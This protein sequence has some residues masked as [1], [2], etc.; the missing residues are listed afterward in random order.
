[1]LENEIVSV[2][3]VAKAMG[4]DPLW[5]RRNWR[6][7]HRTK[8]FPPALPGSDLM[9]PRQLMHAWLQT[10]G[11]EP[12]IADTDFVARANAALH[13]QMETQ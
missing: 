4:R 10:G 2:D 7:L 3:E 1:M 6:R 11:A 13:K 5:I 8:S 12:A 9:F